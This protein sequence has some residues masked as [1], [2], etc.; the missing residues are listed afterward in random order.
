[1]ETTIDTGSSATSLHAG[2]VDILSVLTLAVFSIYQFYVWE[3]WNFDD[4]YIVYRIVLNILEGHGW[5]YNVGEYHNASTSVLNTVLIT[6]GSAPFYF[7]DRSVIPL[8]AHVLN[9]SCI[10]LS[11]LCAYLYLKKRSHPMIGLGTAAILIHLLANSASWGLETHL[12][13]FLSL[14]FLLLQERHY[15]PYLVSGLLVLARPDGALFGIFL[16]IYRLFSKKW[17]LK[18]IVVGSIVAGLI[19]APWLLYSL[20]TFGQ[21]F[22]DTLSN[23]MWQGESGLWGT[24]YVYLKGLYAHL[25]DCWYLIPLAVPGFYYGVRKC[26]ALLYL[27]FFC[28]VQQAVYSILN[29]PAYHWYFVSLDVCLLL[30]SALGLIVVLPFLK[31]AESHRHS[32]PLVSYGA[33]SIALAFVFYTLYTAQFPPRID[34]RDA[35]Y[36][37]AI[38]VL[39]HKHLPS[40]ALAVLEAGTP[41]F[42][43]DRTI[44]DL[45]G[46]V[47]K[48]PPYVSGDFNDQFFQKPPQLLL[49]QNP[50]WH[51]ERGI[52]DDVRFEMLYQ[53]VADSAHAFRNMQI[54]TLT[55]RSETISKEAVGKYIEKHFP[56]VKKT[57]K[58]SISEYSADNFLC[59]ID[60]VNGKLAKDPGVKI[61]GGLL[62][63]N[64]WAAVTDP[65]LA[66]TKAYLALVKG[67]SLYAV[68][69]QRE[70][71]PDVAQAIN[72]PTLKNAGFSGKASIA[73]LPA[74]AYDI[75]IV[76][77]EAQRFCVSGKVLH[78]A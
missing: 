20:T 14:A 4:A 76:E 39:Y 41:G 19:V 52:T 25:K 45:I 7:G 3:Y 42:F 78:R 26:D 34:Q 9:S 36:R 48:N 65:A 72:L 8:V 29:V 62:K 12:F 1:M 68:S 37:K 60:Q 38:D 73:S 57:T 74:G 17:G 27:V 50:I 56:Q 32:V 2:S 35:A 13:S 54:F 31:K 28:A 69:L 10:F 61:K 30:L 71:R 46:L 24:G 70:S 23:K 47:S 66:S 58:A 40:G 64:G 53:K 49:L 18:N 6:A 21:L 63:V 16:V 43:S 51:F 15:S 67:D 22:P 77:P 11:A 44:V 5:V 33:S 59:V 55:G 75:Y